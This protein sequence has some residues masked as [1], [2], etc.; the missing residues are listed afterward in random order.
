MDPE[1]DW[2]RPPEWFLPDKTLRDS[3]WSRI[4]PQQ[5]SVSGV[6]L[7]TQRFQTTDGDEVTVTRGRVKPEMLPHSVTGPGG[8]FDWL[9][10]AGL[11][12]NLYDEKFWND[13]Y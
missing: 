1:V 9:S 10:P 6:L 8:N 13:A 3:F 5:R 11:E 12:G 2:K 4:C 7:G